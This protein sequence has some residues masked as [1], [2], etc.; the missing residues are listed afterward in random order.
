[1]DRT[2]DRTPGTDAADWLAAAAAEPAACHREWAAGCLALLPA[3]RG[4]D[5]LLVPGRLAEPTLTTLTRFCARQGPVY[6]YD[7]RLGFLVPAG[8]AARWVGTGI[9]AAG[10]GSWIALPH[11][12]RTG[13]DLRWRV[14]PDGS[15]MLTDPVLLEL[16]LHDT[17]ARTYER[18]PRRHPDDL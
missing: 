16:A 11:P 1:M 2:P 18:Q 6:A 12:A 13:G 5:V 7:D 10:P 4:W 14:P 9:G 15:G 8:T 3:G 17:A